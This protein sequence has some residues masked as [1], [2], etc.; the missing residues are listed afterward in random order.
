MVN[1]VLPDLK[2]GDWRRLH[3]LFQN[4]L[5]LMGVALGNGAARSQDQYQ[6]YPKKLDRAKSHNVLF[7]SIQRDDPLESYTETLLIALSLCART[8]SGKFALDSTQRTSRVWTWAPGLNEIAVHSSCA[9][10]V[11]LPSTHIPLPFT[12]ARNQSER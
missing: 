7:P 6:Q 4:F 2:V 3:H 12:F 9:T 8:C 11:F 1:D 5:D 10:E